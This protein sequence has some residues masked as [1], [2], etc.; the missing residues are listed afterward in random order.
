MNRK[1]IALPVV[2]ALA[3]SA[4]A[5]P[6]VLNVAGSITSGRDTMISQL[7]ALAPALFGLAVVI[8]IFVFA[9]N[10]VRKLARGR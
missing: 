3:G 7:N 2:A 8:A 1:L 10:W 9:L 4:L 6:P 5:T